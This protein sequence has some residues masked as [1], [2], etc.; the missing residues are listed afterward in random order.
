MTDVGSDLGDDSDVVDDIC[1]QK[2]PKGLA[3]QYIH[4]RLSPQWRCSFLTVPIRPQLKLPQVAIR[5]LDS[6]KFVVTCVCLK[7][8]YP[9]ILVHL[10]A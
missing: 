7:T 4:E 1:F 5:C 9:Q 2:I 8:K 3:L 6:L 10:M